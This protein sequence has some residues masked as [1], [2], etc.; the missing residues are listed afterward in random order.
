MEA[1]REAIAVMP[2]TV[3]DRSSP[4]PSLLFTSLPSHALTILPFHPAQRISLV[5]RPRPPSR[6]SGSIAILHP[7][8]TIVAIAN[9]R[10]C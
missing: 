4:T 8:Y 6:W 1:S 2:A 9:Y 5:P 7:D 3:K 10:I